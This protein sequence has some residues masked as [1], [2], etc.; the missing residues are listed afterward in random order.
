MDSST[1]IKANDV[2]IILRPTITDK[3]WDGDYQIMIGG[4]GPFTLSQDEVRSLTSMAMIIAAVVPAM[5]KDEKLTEQLMLECADYYCEQDSDVLTEMMVDE[6]V[7]NAN[8][9]TYGGMQ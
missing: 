9:K 4:F 5:E 2:V 1:E 8:T 3:G 7:L 6:F